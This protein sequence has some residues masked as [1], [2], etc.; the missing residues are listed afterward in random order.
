MHCKNRDKK[1]QR[2]EIKKYF[3]AKAE[4]NNQKKKKNLKK[5][6]RKKKKKMVEDMKTNLRE[7]YDKKRK[8]RESEFGKYMAMPATGPESKPP[9]AM[10]VA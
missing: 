3:V 9:E 5:T 1:L 7:K 4:M 6:R 8:D 10:E 2:I